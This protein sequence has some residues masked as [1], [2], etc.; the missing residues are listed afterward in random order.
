MS[1]TRLFFK[2]SLSINFCSKLDISQ[3]HYISKVM[4]ISEG[5]TFS[6]FNES[7]E[8]EAQVNKIE[9]GIIN[10]VILQKLRST[11]KGID[12]WLAFT[13]IKINYLNF[14]IQK[15]TELG[16]TKFIPILTERTIVRDINTIRIKKII[17]EAAEQSNR[18]NIP[19]IEKLVSF[20]KFLQMNKNT[21]I[22][23]GDLNSKNN[24]IKIDDKKPNCILVGPEGDFS[25]KEREKILNFKNIHSFRVNENILRTETAAIS[26]ISVVNFF[27]LSE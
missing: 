13:P 7:G 21:N 10:F 18:I 1:H 24:K 5:Q 17:I 25:E 23:F 6:L 12:L 19:S 26:L 2:E 27:R 15:A 22:I 20:E 9:K 11:D 14:M 16:V 8:W 3:S 4:R